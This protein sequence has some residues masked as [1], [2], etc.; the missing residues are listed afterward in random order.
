MSTGTRNVVRAACI[1]LAL[2]SMVA[3]TARA[4]DDVDV[5]GTITLRTDAGFAMQTDQEASVLVTLI[6][7]T[8][9]FLP[10]GTKM[11]ASDLIP[12]LRVKVSGTYDAGG[13]R[14]T[15]REVKFTESDQRLARAIKAGLTPTDQQVAA[16][17]VD[18]QKG[19][20]VLQQHGQTLDTHGQTIHKQGE[21]IV[22]NDQKMIATTGALGSRIGNLD[23]FDIVDTM[24]VYFKNGRTNVSKDYAAQLQEFAAKAKAVHGYKIQVLGYASAVGSQTLNQRLSDDRAENVTT[25]LAQKGGIPPA[26]I[27]HP[28]GMGTSEQFAA[29]KTLKGQ[30]ENRRVIVTIL[31]NKGIADR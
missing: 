6:D 5:K 31:Q 16:N 24:I 21:D 10:N 7:T 22:A 26:N 19:A 29:N 9:I 15:A 1:V 18:I 12:G 4:D 27:F 30:A 2:F 8:R 14:L 23:D 28:E 25:L 17:T 11:P 20:V 3:S 13:T